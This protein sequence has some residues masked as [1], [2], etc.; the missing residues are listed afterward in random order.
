MTKLFLLITIILSVS[1]SDKKDSYKNPLTETVVNNRNFGKELYQNEFLKYSDTL[2]LDSLKHNLI[3][4]FDIYNE[5]IFRLI[6]VD[7]EELAEFSFDFFLPNLNKVLKKRS[8][9][10][11]IRKS[12]Q[13]EF[14]NTIFINEEEIMLYSQYDLENYTFWDVAPRRFFSKINE[15]LKKQ[16]SNEKFFLLYE[17]NDL[18]VILLTEKQFKIICEKYEYNKRDIPYLP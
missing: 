5:D 1:C 12:D 10:I 17:G 6:H 7:A 14:N 13:I 18:H 11:S 15:L 3:N 4:E 16:N 9:E 8:F 2:K